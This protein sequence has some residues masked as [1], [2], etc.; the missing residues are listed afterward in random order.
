MAVTLNHTGPLGLPSGLVLRP[1]VATDVPG[2]FT[3]RNHPVV[4]H[5]L[6]VGVLSQSDAKTIETKKPDPLDHDGDGRKGGSKPA[7]QGE[8]LTKLRA[9]YQEVYGKKAFHGWGADELRA[10][11]DAK[12]AE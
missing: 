6:K 9:D 11:I 3:L 2:W 7:E 10:K 1:G 8:D 12:L 4:A 5:W